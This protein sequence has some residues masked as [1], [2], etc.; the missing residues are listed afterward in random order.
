MEKGVR[1]SQAGT[2]W[3]DTGRQ[4]QVLMD[5]VMRG[6]YMGTWNDKEQVSGRTWEKV[7][8]TRW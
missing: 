3:A 1:T 8:Q 2:V 6:A 5:Q 4:G 7:R